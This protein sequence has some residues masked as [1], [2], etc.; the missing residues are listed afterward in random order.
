MKN[1]T[2]NLRV[3]VLGALC[4]FTSIHAGAQTLQTITPPVNNLEKCSAGI[5]H[6]HLMETDAGYN[7][8]MHQY[9]QQVVNIKNSLTPK[10]NALYKIPVVV[11]VLHKGEAVGTGTNVSD[12]DIRKA[13]RNLNERYRKASGTA[14][15]GN[16]VDM[17]IEFALAVR[18]PSGQCTN[19]ITRTSMTGNTNYMN[20]G[21]QA[22]TNTGITDAALKAVISWDRTKYYNIYLVSEFDNNEGGAGVQGYAYMATSHGANNDGAAILAANFTAEFTM[23]TTHELGHA[24]NLFHTFEGDG[25]GSSCPS[26]TNGCGSGLGDC[27]ADIPPHRRSQSNCN[28]TGTNSCNGN[29]SNAL[30][31]R[32]YMDY[33]S[34]DCVNMFTADQKTRAQAAC[35]GLRASFFAASN[36]ALVPVT[37]PTVD[38]TSTSSMICTGQTVQFFDASSCVPNTYLE[39]TSWNNITFSWTFTSGTTVLTSSFQNP[40]I[41]F[42]TPGTYD[43]ALTV[44]TPAGTATVTKTA[45]VVYG[46]SAVAACTPTSTNSGTTSGQTISNVKFNTINNSTDVYVNYAYQNFVCTKNTTVN[47]GTTYPLSITVNAGPNGGQVFEV[48]IDYNN[49]GVF[50]ATEKVHSGFV[51]KGTNSSLNSAILQTNVTIPATAVTNTL[52]R[53]RVISDYS[54]TV[55]NAS[56]TVAATKRTCSASFVVGDNEDYGVYIKQACTV[57]PIISVQPAAQAI[58]EGAN[59]SI[60]VTATNATTYQWQVSTNGG[61]TWTNINNGGVYSNA[62]TAAL[63]ITAATITMNNYKYRCATTNTCGNTNTS[64]VTLTVTAAPSVSATTPGNRCGTGTVV[65]GATASAGTLSWYAAATGGTA[66]GSG[67]SFTTPSISTT[68]TY[69][70]AATNNGCSTPTRTAVI[71][72]VNQNVAMTSNPSNATICAGANITLTATGGSSY[73]WSS[74]QTSA[75]I[76]VSPTTNTTYTVTGVSTCNTT[77]T[78]NVI[79]TPLPSASLATFPQACVNNTTFA[80]TQGTPAGGTYSGTG[81]T[82]NNF[83]PSVAGLGSKVITYTVTANGCSKSVTGNIIV[84]GCLGIADN[85]SEDLLIIYPNPVEGFMTVEGENLSKYSVIEL[86]DVT[87]KLVSNWNVES[88][89]MNIDMTQ[90]ANGNYTVKIVGAENIVV[91]KIQILK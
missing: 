22:S 35:A 56:S 73:S 52:L 83:N 28:V 21:V 25:T 30:F 6:Q 15:F 85:A 17:Q 76:T 41:T 36:L 89:K 65:L 53:M 18:N 59:T 3:F 23:T 86:R 46:A 5:I 90:F 71:A 1:K 48:Y 26:Q 13:I 14:G 39:E 64:D 33:A 61:T 81:V 68:T 80:L 32:N 16:G 11:H 12:A 72:T 37:A 42:T 38:F 58:C 63:T 88:A 75:S 8:R 87:G 34:D 7:A 67:I 78:V 20:N 82:G 10:A 9:E 77:A 79:V 51:T 66:L 70:V 24:L 27:C 44:T 31:A 50:D 69:Y 54:S 84:D 4:L 47:V 60:S 91:K 62:T 45:F 55:P 19:G 57:A 43:V 40:V 74:G 29:S 2:F 49:N